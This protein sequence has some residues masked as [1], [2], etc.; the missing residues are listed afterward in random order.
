MMTP[1]LKEL[2]KSKIVDLMIPF[3]FKEVFLNLEFIN[4]L[5]D[6]NS[7]VK[8]ECYDKI[9]DLTDF[10]FNYE[11]INQPNINKSKIEIF[12]DALRVFCSETRTYIKLSEK[13]ELWANEFIKNNGLRKGKIILIAVRSAN[14]SRDWGIDKW[15]QLIYRLKTLNYDIIV[16]DRELNWA[17]EKIIF[18]NNHSIRE[19]FSLVSISDAILC[20]DSGVLHI[21]GALEKK[22][23]GI[24]GPTDPRQRCLY[25]TTYWVDNAK[26][27]QFSWYDRRNYKDF[28]DAIS[29]GD[30]ERAFLEVISDESS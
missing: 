14:P 13:E 23:L 1:A 9:F 16:V 2:S 3:D 10:E 19:L 6:I 20:N 28:F 29:V 30:V 8:L 18:F 27:I 22:T 4:S 15:K 25:K 11:Q 17:D 21:G 12:A 7:Q 26:G 5:I 24:F